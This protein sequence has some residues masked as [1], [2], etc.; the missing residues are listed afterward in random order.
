LEKASGKY[1]DLIVMSK[2]LP[3]FEFEFGKFSWFYLCL[4]ILCG[5]SCLFILWCAGNRCGMVGCDDDYGWTRRPGVEDRGW[6]SIDHIL[7]GQMIERL[8]DVVCGLHRAQ[9]DEEHRFI[10]L[11]LKPKSTVCQSFGLK[12]IGSDFLV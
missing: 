3:R 6:S 9:G 10:G 1:L 5:E 7:G 2:N 4:S 12:T 8:C 11:A